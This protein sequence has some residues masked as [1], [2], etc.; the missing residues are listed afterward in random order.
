MNLKQ[1]F[2]FQEQQFDR[3]FPFYILINGDMQVDATGKTLEKLFPLTSGKQFDESFFIKRPELEHDVF[4]SLQ[5]LHA[6]L[7]VIECRNK[8]RTSL[9]GQIE[10]L[11]ATNQLLFLGSPWFGAIEQV[12]ENNLTLHDFAYHDPM[13]DLLH[14][15]KTQEI[16]TEDLKHLLKTINQQ[17][18]TLKKD[19]AELERLSMVASANENGIVFTDETGKIFWCNEGMQHITGRSKEEIIGKTPVELL[20]GPLTDK[21]V[22]KKM[23]ND[24]ANHRSFQNE[25]IHYSK[26]GSWYWGK[27]KGQAIKNKDGKVNYFALIEDI[28]VQKAKEEQLRILSSIAAENTHG[29][30]IADEEG[31]V[32][33]INKSFE[34]IT[35]YTLDEMK[36]KKPG[37]LLQGP[38]TDP[39]TVT[40]IK[41]QIEKGEP[42][43]CEILNYHK[44]RSKYWLRLQG[45]ALKDERGKVVKYF[46]IEEDITRE[47]EFNQQLKDFETRFRLALEKIGDNVWE[48]DF[49][50]GVTKF[51]RTKNNFIEIDPD[52]NMDINKLWWSSIHKD[53]LPMLIENDQNCR[54]GKI[55]YHR[56]EYRMVKKD[57]T[58][59]WV[60]DR[61]VVL[62]KDQTGKPLLIIGT[63]TDI[64]NQ[65]IIQQ[66]L[67]LAKNA[68]EASTLS[69]EMFLANMSHEIR[70]PMNAISG[71]AN[72]LSKTNL[73]QDQQFYL[74]TIQSAT[75]NLLIIINDILDLSKIEAGKLSIEQIGF[76]PK[77]IVNRAMQVMM[78]RAEEKGLALTNSYC[79][80]ML[81]PVLIGDP[82]RLNQVLLNLLSNAI[83]FTEKGSVD[84]TCKIINETNLDQTVEVSVADTG[85]GMDDLFLKNLFQ[86]FSQ[87]DES[88][89]R[90]F[91][92]TGLGM[93]I[94]KELIELM[95]GTIEVKSKKE[96][97]TTVGFTIMF[98]KGTSGDLA[99]K[100]T[101]TFNT[102]IL[103][104]KKILVTDDNEMNRLVASTVLK[105]Y[106]AEIEEA[107][108]GRD[109]INKL[110]SQNYDIILMDVQMPV[111]D[112]MEATEEIRKTISKSVPIIALT[113]YAIKG[114]DAKF[115]KA[116]MNDYLSKPFEENQLLKVVAKWLKK[117]IQAKEDIK[118][119]AASNGLYDLTKLEAIA[120]GNT[121]FVNKMVNLFKEQAPATM[122]EIE[123][124]YA[125]QNFEKVGKLA[126][127]LKPSIDNMGISSL[128]ETIRDMETNAVAY[129]HSEK[130]SLLISETRNCI[131]QVVNTLNN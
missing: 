1:A 74:G 92:G 58:I 3:L 84:I 119:T 12:I 85:I 93:S 6:Q 79:D 46:A 10:F 23:V 33:W 8:Q 77:M 116:G 63:H 66:E 24:F 107:H 60:L 26:D 123:E 127:R 78:H 130:L 56:L 129:G 64:T 65:K 36:G 99:V 67:I 16:T 15:L 38:E 25:L 89:T 28:S 87:E 48:H 14:V 110:H 21:E 86:K 113:A 83:K 39:E 42:F 52:L 49:R 50:T 44:N 75:D 126:H 41:T 68:A 11:P 122:L 115:I 128:K 114:D 109:A 59:S 47:K 72:Q 81:S 17:K 43:V 70:T 118:V 34:K 32:E 102:N 88:I 5:S 30:V 91:G 108:N 95:G 55:D 2:V 57:G 71:M 19:K 54:K 82:Y 35:G 96:A 62:E 97:G 18:E 121:S 125:Q 131:Q 76:E 9:R 100:E 61:G 20:R 51:S 27:T 98:R 106:G 111:M 103:A 13:I 69:K 22:I 120:R 94:C 7:V 80:S 29:V 101:E 90:K 105:T 45:Q 124:A 4:N 53:D 31:E 37:H 112:G 40:Y 117:E 73:N 104:G